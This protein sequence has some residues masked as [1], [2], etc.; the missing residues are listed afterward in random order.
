ME[1]SY[2]SSLY[3]W[4]VQLFPIKKISQKKIKLQIILPQFFRFVRESFFLKR[5]NPWNTETF[6]IN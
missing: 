3:Y 6:S 1:S 5:F 4:N 2:F